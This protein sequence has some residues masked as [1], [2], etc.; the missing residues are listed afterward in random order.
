[1]V[2]LTAA[3]ALGGIE[4]QSSQKDRPL[5]DDSLFDPSELSLLREKGVSVPSFAVLNAES[6]DTFQSI[7][8][9]DFYSGYEGYDRDWFYAYSART[10]KA[11][12]IRREAIPVRQLREL[13]RRKH[14]GDQEA[15]RGGLTA[16][17]IIKEFWAW[18]KRA[19]LTRSVPVFDIRGTVSHPEFAVTEAE[20]ASDFEAALLKDDGSYDGYDASWFYV[21]SY[22]SARVYK[23]SRDRLTTSQLKELLYER[24]QRDEAAPFDRPAEFPRI[25]EHLDWLNRAAPEPGA[26]AR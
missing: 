8:L 3:V 21:F 2:I 11:Y 6:A 20:G 10:V 24:Q 19:W 16:K 7:V 1:M 25:R 15:A 26:P 17:P 14:A 5:S 23:I 18:Q 22:R 4:G 9:E 12:R 13:L